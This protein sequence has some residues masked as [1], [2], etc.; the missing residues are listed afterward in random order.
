MYA[1]RTIFSRF[2]LEGNENFTP[3]FAIK[4]HFFFS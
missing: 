4:R 2:V 1:K 3:I